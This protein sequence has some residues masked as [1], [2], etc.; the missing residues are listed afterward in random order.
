MADILGVGLT[1]SPSLI[2]PD[3]LK[4]YSLTRAL[5]NNDRTPGGKE[6]PR[7]LAGCHAR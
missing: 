4:N 1:H 2:T 5:R 3:E 7:I 6:E